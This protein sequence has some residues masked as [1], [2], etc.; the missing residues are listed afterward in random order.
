MV[1]MNINDLSSDLT[2]EELLDLETATNS[3]IVHDEDS[4][5]MTEEMLRQFKRMNKEARVKQTVSLRLSPST[6]KKAKSLGKGYTSVLSSLLDLAI[7]DE[8]M[9]KKCL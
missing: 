6:L 2:E 4:P 8:E 3:P 7:N 1:K 5:E 9:L